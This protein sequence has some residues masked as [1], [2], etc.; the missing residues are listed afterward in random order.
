M[1]TLPCVYVT[2]QGCLGATSCHSNESCRTSCLPSQIVSNKQNGVDVDKWD[3]FSRDCHHL[4]L[5]NSF[6]H[7]R[8]IASMKVVVED[9]GVSHIAARDKVCGKYVCVVHVVAVEGTAVD[10]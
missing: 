5:P 8:V 6:D 4:G 10:I 2:S 9:D 1:I 3:Y 7:N